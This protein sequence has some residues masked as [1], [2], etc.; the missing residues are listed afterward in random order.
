M[1]TRIVLAIEV[2]DRDATRVRDLLERIVAGP[3][4]GQRATVTTE[5][6]TRDEEADRL[7]AVM[8]APVFDR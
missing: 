7:T 1:T 5:P 6:L 3:A 2:P 8:L 4:R